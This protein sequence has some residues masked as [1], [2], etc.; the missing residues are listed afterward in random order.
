MGNIV[1]IGN[2]Q[3]TTAFN[4]MGNLANQAAGESI[5]DARIDFTNYQTDQDMKGAVV[6]GLTSYGLNSME[7]SPAQVTQP[8][9]GVISPFNTSGWSTTGSNNNNPYNR[10]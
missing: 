3:E 2:G 8:E 4:S 9:S 7:S 6:G 10:G 5:N 1:A